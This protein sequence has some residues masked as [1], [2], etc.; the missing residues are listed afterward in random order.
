MS[1][2]PPRQR[3][4]P[5]E[6]IDTII[7]ELGDEPASLRSCA[8]VHPAWCARAQYHLF[9]EITIPLF[10]SLN[11]REHQRLFRLAE[12]LIKKPELAH[13]VHSLII[14]GYDDERGCINQ[15]FLYFE[16]RCSTLLSII[17]LLKHV[18]KVNVED[19][20]DFIAWGKIGPPLQHAIFELI[21]QRSVTELRVL[22]VDG[23]PILP[24]LWCQ[25][26]KHIELRSIDTDTAEMDAPFPMNARDHALQLSEASWR[27]LETLIL[28]DDDN[29]PALLQ[30][31]L[32]G[33]GARLSNLKKLLLGS[34]KWDEPSAK[35]D[36][37]QLFEHVQDS[38]EIYEVKQ[39]FSK[40]LLRFDLIPN[41]Q[42]LLFELNWYY[43]NDSLEQRNTMSDITE[44]LK[45]LA[46][47]GNVL[48]T[49]ELTI[50]FDHPHDTADEEQIYLPRHWFDQWVALDDVLSSPHF[51]SLVPSSEGD[52]IFKSTALVTLNFDELK[53]QYLPGPL[54][55]VQ[56]I[57]RILEDMKMLQITR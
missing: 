49:F 15:D 50:D 40:S 45:L 12:S 25:H 33:N 47:P 24:G 32:M 43:L 9:R 16:A 21:M 17:P 51:S 52:D 26:L 53:C 1:P 19:F 29:D 55:D 28:D 38:L 10:V 27:W 11:V 39:V 6:L 35:A 31:L 46:V 8:L 37:L 30:Y 34:S 4:L 2:P 5:R 23:M 44:A 54:G 42:T 57:L 13:L 48:K 3:H 22:S 18:R 41:L 14:Q 36:L 7:D 56:P 20:F